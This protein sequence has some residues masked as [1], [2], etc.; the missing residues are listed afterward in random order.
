[1]NHGEA[2]I[3]GLEIGSIVGH[4]HGRASEGP[5]AHALYLDDFF[6]RGLALR[7]CV[8]TGRDDR[9]ECGRQQK[10]VVR[11]HYPPLSSSALAES[12]LFVLVRG[13]ALIRHGSAALSGNAPRNTRFPN[14]PFNLT[15]LPFEPSGSRPQLVSAETELWMA[16]PAKWGQVEGWGVR[17]NRGQNVRFAPKPTACAVRPSFS[18]AQHR[19]T[20]SNCAR[21][22]SIRS[23]ETQPSE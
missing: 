5:C 20:R 11:H 3:A 15:G 4:R 14:V 2:V 19:M 8:K 23:I 9:Q 13:K 1:M 18:F 16:K 17:S 12:Q 10:R 21:V 22:S 6:G 7:K